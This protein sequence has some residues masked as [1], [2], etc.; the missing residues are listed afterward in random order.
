MKKLKTKT[1]P[2]KP[3]SG[4]FPPYFAG[5]DDEVRTFEQKLISTLSGASIQCPLKANLPN[6]DLKQAKSFDNSAYQKA[7]DMHYCLIETEAENM[8]ERIDIWIVKLYN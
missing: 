5:R 8:K 6:K 4:L 7:R 3:G 1:N 2:F